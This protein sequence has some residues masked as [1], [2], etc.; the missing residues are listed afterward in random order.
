[1]NKPIYEKKL[2]SG[3]FQVFLKKPH[4]SFCEVNQ[5]H[6]R[7]IVVP[8]QS[9]C[10]A[11]GI[12][13]RG[14]NIESSP[15]LAIKTADCLPLVILGRKGKALL[16]AGWRGIQQKI[17]LHEAIHQIHPYFAFAGPHI[18]AQS[19]EVGDEFSSHFPDSPELL[20]KVGSHLTFDLFSQVKKDLEAAFSPIEVINS[21]LDTLTDKRFHS[22]RRDA[23]AQRNYNIYRI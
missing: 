13:I 23:T 18:Q 14:E 5:V 7:T 1:M 3:S 4:F 17:H 15:C 11:D 19:F 16:H 22:Y 8:S 2:P 12:V 10:S 6:G 9:P 20:Q 21:N